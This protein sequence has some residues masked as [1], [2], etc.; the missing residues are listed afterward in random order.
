MPDPTVRELMRGG[1]VT[2]APETTL[3]DLLTVMGEH[4]ASAFIVMDNGV[5]LGLILRT[6]LMDPGFPRAARG[7]WR[8]KTARDLMTGTVVSIAVEAPLY[9]ALQLLRHHRTH[10]L[11]VTQSDPEGSRTLGV[12]TMSDILQGL[13]R[14]GP[15]AP[16]PGAAPPPRAPVQWPGMRGVPFSA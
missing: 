11:V 7:H 1:A 4:D 13:G 15:A 10:R 8:S 9:D 5:A 2:G 14:L 16:A 12:L 6:E 3:D